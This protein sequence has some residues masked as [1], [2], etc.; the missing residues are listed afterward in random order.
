MVWCHVREIIQSCIHDFLAFRPKPT[1]LPPLRHDTRVPTPTAD[2]HRRP[3]PRPYSPLS[4]RPRLGG[5]GGSTSR[6]FAAV[7][8]ATATA[9]VLLSGAAAATAAPADGDG[10]IGLHLLR[11]VLRVRELVCSVCV[12]VLGHANKPPTSPHQS[13]R[14]PTWQHLVAQHPVLLLPPGVHPPARRDDGGVEG[15]ARELA[16]HVRAWLVGYKDEM[17][18]VSRAVR[19]WLFIFKYLC[20]GGL[21]GLH[22]PP[23]Y[24]TKQPTP[25][26]YPT[27][28]PP[29]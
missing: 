20:V 25:T 4:T 13:T 26:P 11:P 5:G 21:D 16:C 12:C 10:A 8:A 19:A 6:V 27:P 24:R 3:H 23:S 17:V 29:A 22:A 14:Q 15:P 28:Y 18:A 9:A 1:H 2:R 7:A